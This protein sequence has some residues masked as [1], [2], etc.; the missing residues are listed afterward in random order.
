MWRIL[1]ITGTKI[2]FEKSSA[3]KRICKIHMTKGRQNA[4]RI[5]NSP[6]GN[7]E[8]PGVVSQVLYCGVRL[9]P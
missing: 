3:E 1:G 6:S 7:M 4:G 5:S 8:R 2:Y 9:I